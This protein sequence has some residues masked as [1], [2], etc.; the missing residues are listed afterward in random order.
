MCAMNV[1][2]T[3]KNTFIGALEVPTSSCGS[4][5]LRSKSLP[6]SLRK[7]IEDDDMMHEFG[8]VASLMQRSEQLKLFL[9]V[10]SKNPNS[11][12]SK[13][14][15]RADVA[16]PGS[17]STA[18]EEQQT[19]WASTVD[20]D[21]VLDQAQTTLATLASPNSFS[22]SPSL[23]GQPVACNPGSAGHPELC[24]RP[25]MFAA[26]GNCGSGANCNFCHMVHKHQNLDKRLRNQLRSLND[27]ERVSLLACAIR[28]RI[29]TIG[30]SSQMS[31]I[32]EIFEVWEASLPLRS[33]AMPCVRR[34]RQALVKLP[35]SVLIGQCIGHEK[36]SNAHFHARLRGAMQHLSN[37]L[38]SR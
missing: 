9:Q 32:L 30:L 19:S 10:K 4:A 11:S 26:T 2:L 34:L 22:G 12:M 27:V 1:Q 23:S 14:D 35:L 6:S 29:E 16:S 36:D 5:C 17:V 13:K 15:H 24:R 38:R 21:S 18:L 31:E 33:C 20:T 25:C 3:Y 7:S 8:Y 37:S 28:E